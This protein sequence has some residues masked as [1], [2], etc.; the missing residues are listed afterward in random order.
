MQILLNEE[1]LLV[2]AANW[3]FQNPGNSTRS[4][5]YSTSKLKVYLVCLYRISRLPI[6]RNSSVGQKPI[7]TPLPNFANRAE[8]SNTITPAAR[9]NL[10]FSTGAAATPV[11]RK[12]L[13]EQAA[14][15]VETLRNHFGSNFLPDGLSSMTAKQFI[16]TISYFMKNV[17]GNERGNRLNTTNLTI[18]D[19]TKYL[20]ELGYATNNKQSMSWMKT[21]NAP[22]SLGKLVDL[23]QWFCVFLP[24]PDGEPHP[25]DMPENALCDDHFQNAEYVEFF[26]ATLK[27]SFTLWNNKRK[28]DFESSKVQLID[29]YIQM[30]TP[31][32]SKAEIESEV[33]KIK[34]KLKE[35]LKNRVIV[36][37]NAE[38]IEL[39]VK[40]KHIR[41]KIDELLSSC[42]EKTAERDKVHNLLNQEEIIVQDLRMQVSQLTKTIAQQPYSRADIELKIGILAKQRDALELHND[43]I[44][45]LK[46]I[47]FNNQVKFARA[48]KQQNEL[49]ARFNVMVHEEFLAIGEANWFGVTL[50]DLS[51]NLEDMNDLRGQIDRVFRNFETIRE[52][53]IRES[54]SIRLKI[55]AIELQ[56]QAVQKNYDVELLKNE[57]VIEKIATLKEQLGEVECEIQR[58]QVEQDNVMEEIDELK[59][60]IGSKEIDRSNLDAQIVQIRDDNKLAM[61]EYERKGEQFMEIKRERQNRLHN[62]ITEIRQ[63]LQSLKNEMKIQKPE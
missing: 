47:G 13:N 8:S 37:E 2:R 19:I 62:A 39:S 50:S 49:A 40:E 29:K 14:Q 11:D 53:N 23:L 15:V 26:N 31:V 24:P 44:N 38:L 3:K 4:S 34:S 9:R 25:F 43:N 33:V 1:C 56:L 20:I 36:V 5:V 61:Q 12:Q 52:Q 58:L 41:D 7:E 32:H 57:N 45:K 48:I 6:K 30:H 55:V 17:V 59:V 54:D 18:D 63:S 35:E 16:A 60:S 10:G 46:N 51:I 22:H 27:D 21:P 28:E 42:D